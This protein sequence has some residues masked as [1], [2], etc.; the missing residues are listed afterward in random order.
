MER[1]HAISKYFIKTTKFTQQQKSRACL[2]PKFPF[3]YLLQCYYN[4]PANH[5][6]HNIHKVCLDTH[7]YHIRPF[8][9]FDDTDPKTPRKPQERPSFFIKPDVPSQ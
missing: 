8:A 4:K 1:Q 5:K 2:N 6:S 3:L 9:G 7:A